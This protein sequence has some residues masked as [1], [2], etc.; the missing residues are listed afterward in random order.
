MKKTYLP[1]IALYFSFAILPAQFAWAGGQES[2]SSVFDDINKQILA[3]NADSEFVYEHGPA[4]TSHPEDLKKQLDEKVRPRLREFVAN[5]S[6]IRQ[7][8]DAAVK[9][10]CTGVNKAEVK[11]ALKAAGAILDNIA[12]LESEI[13]AKTIYFGKTGEELIEMA[14]EASPDYPNCP[15]TKENDSKSTRP[16]LAYKRMRRNLERLSQNLDSVSEMLNSM[17]KGKNISCKSAALYAPLSKDGFGGAVD[18]IVSGKI[19]N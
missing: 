11:P 16:M 10:G 15:A 9:L 1:K 5:A 2:L 7:T 14:L 12:G 13:A 8:V 18:G 17:G 19:S 3:V 4:C 6:I